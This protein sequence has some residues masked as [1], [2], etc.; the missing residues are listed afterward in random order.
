MEI[1]QSIILVITIVLLIVATL[2]HLAKQAD[3]DDIILDD[4]KMWSPYED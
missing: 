1:I 3:K 2:L 4:K